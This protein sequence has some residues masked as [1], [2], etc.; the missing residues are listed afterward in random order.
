MQDI[1]DVK[2]AAKLT[3]DMQ[4]EEMLRRDTE[5]TAAA[6]SNTSSSNTAEVAVSG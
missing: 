1:E 3:R 5:L 4:E 6:V 2:I